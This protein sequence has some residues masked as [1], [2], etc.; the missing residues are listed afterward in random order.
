MALE[1]YPQD[2]AIGFDR[3]EWIAHCNTIAAK[4]E[5]PALSG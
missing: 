3:A 5:D 4:D 1:L 2:V